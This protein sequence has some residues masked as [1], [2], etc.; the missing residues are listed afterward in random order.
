MPEVTSY[1]P[2]TPSWVDLTTSDPEAARL[3]YGR[4]FGWEFDIGSEE[5]GNYTTCQLDDR[6]V[7]GMSGQPAPEGMPTF[8]TTYLASDDVDAVA[9]RV[10]D[11]G[12][13][14]M[15]APM[16]VMPFG[17]MLIA[18]DP[19]GAAFGAWQAGEL[20]GASLV[21]EPGTL[22]WNELATRDLDAAQDFYTKVFGY[23][24]GDEDTGEGGPVYRFFQ[25][26][27]KTVG[28]SLQMTGDWP[29]EIPAHWMPYFG[30][31]DTDAAASEAER[32]GGSV[33]VPA[34]DSSYGRFAVLNDPQGGLFTVVQSSSG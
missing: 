8:W 25:V 14:I 11:N 20:I 24:W 32:L 26:D 4:L 29:Q 12:G 7:A 10:S 21:N 22:V 28:G 19:T 17:R 34:T 31:G 9:Q 33:S 3:F 15:M 2:G 13:Q 1:K 6:A 16:D 27:G 30:V 5:Y 18:S 23:T